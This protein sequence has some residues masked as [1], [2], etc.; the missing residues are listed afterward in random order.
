[1]EYTKAVAE[2]S[3][4]II[5][6]MSQSFNIKT[7][8]EGREAH[9]EELRRG[10]NFIV[11]RDLLNVVGFTSWVV[12]GRLKHGLVELNHIAVVLDYQGRGVAARLYEALV[13]DAQKYFQEKGGKLRKLFLLT[14]S[15]NVQAQKFY[16]KMGL[17]H[18]A[19]LSD[20][21]YKGKDEFVMSR[22][23]PIS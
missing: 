18:E 16:E 17:E 5:A 22:F 19:T 2:D 20:H 21:F 8:E 7:L 4:Q 6:I 10:H 3:K 13:A 9:L 12:H 14:H 11:A 23:F 1:M 15:D